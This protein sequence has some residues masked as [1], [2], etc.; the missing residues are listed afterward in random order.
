M[1]LR[2]QNKG[3]WAETFVYEQ[4]AFRFIG[5]GT[6]PFWSWIGGAG[7]TAYNGR[8]VPRMVPIYQIP[9]DYP[10]MARANHIEGVVTLRAIIDKEGNVKTLELIQGDPL[11]VDAAM[12]AVERWRYNPANFAGNPTEADTIV[13]VVFQLRKN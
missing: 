13:S 6:L 10:M 5:L 4:G 7:P 3:S 9:P 11:L 8:V 1:R 2:G 12:T